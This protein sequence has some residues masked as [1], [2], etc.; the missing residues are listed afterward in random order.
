MLCQGPRGS[1]HTEPFRSW[2][3]VL[4]FCAEQRSSLRVLDS[5]GT[6][7]VCMQAR[8]PS[9]SFSGVRMAFKGAET[10]WEESA[11]GC[12]CVAHTDL[13]LPRGF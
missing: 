13:P 11:Q 5:L 10:P 12:H 2:A 6:T 1:Y 3:D 7:C 4:T 8:N 9:C